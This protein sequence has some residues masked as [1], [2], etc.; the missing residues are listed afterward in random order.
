MIM[1]PIPEHSLC[2]GYPDRQYPRQSPRWR[3]DGA[4]GPGFRAGRLDCGEG[5]G[6]RSGQVGSRASWSWPAITCARWARVLR[7]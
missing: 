4:A 5:T 1:P 2:P 6:R 3:R 7:A